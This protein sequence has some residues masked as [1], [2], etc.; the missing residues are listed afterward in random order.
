M[1]HLYLSKKQKKIFG[2]CGGIGELFDMDPTLVRLLV[3]F[4]CFSTAI[5]PVVLTYLIAWA[6]VPEEPTV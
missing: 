2:V 4:L 5:I 6:I 3:V 1:R